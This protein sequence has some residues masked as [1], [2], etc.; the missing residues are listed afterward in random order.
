MGRYLRRNGGRRQSLDKRVA[1]RHIVDTP[2]EAAE[3]QGHHTRS[4]RDKSLHDTNEPLGKARKAGDLLSDPASSLVATPVWRSD[5]DDAPHE[6]K[7]LEKERAA[8]LPPRC[9]SQ[10]K[11]VERPSTHGIP[12]A[13][14]RIDGHHLGE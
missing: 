10:N 13:S 3:G 5:E 9:I 11:I 12:E 7:R 4:T 8:G 14:P 2:R 6:G 1:G